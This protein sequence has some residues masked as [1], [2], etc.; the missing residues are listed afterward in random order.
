MHKSW[1]PFYCLS[2]TQQLSKHSDKIPIDKLVCFY[3]QFFYWSCQATKDQTDHS[4]LYF[5]SSINLMWLLSSIRKLYYKSAF[6]E[7]QEIQLCTWRVFTKSGHIHNYNKFLID[8]ITGFMKPHLIN[9]KLKYLDVWQ[10]WETSPTKAN[11]RTFGSGI[12][13]E[14]LC[15]GIEW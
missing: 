5:I 2:Y 13:I 3:R 12:H 10:T 4:M 11:W 14:S 15:I 1:N 8:E 6:L 9:T 7:I